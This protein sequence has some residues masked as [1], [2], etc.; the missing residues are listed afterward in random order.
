MIR[1]RSLATSAGLAAAEDPDGVAVVDGAETWS[2]RTLDERVGSMAAHLDAA[3]VA[4]GSRVAVLAGPSAGAVAALHAIARIGA[5]AVPFPTS[6][7][8]R[9]LREAIDLTQPALVVVGRGSADAVRR[10]GRPTLALEAAA[11][12]IARTELASAEDRDA[13]AVIVLT[14]GTTGRP[15]AAVLSTRALL[16]SAEAW[17]EALPPASGWLLAV[18]LA[19]VA[20]LGVIWR[21]ALSGVPLVLLER[22]D[23]QGIVS[24]LRSKPRPSHASL[25]PTTL[26]R[27]LDATGDAPPP[28]TL[29][30]VPLGGGWIDPVLV[31]RSLAAGWPVVPTYGLTEAGSGVTALPTSEAAAHAETAG[32]PL[33][34]VSIRIDEPDADGIGEI[35]VDSPGRFSGYLDDR[36]ATATSLTP[37]GWLRTGDVGRLD[38]DGRLIVVDRRTD[39]IV[40]GGEN[41]SPAEVEAVLLTHPA[42]ADAAVVAR[43]DSTFGHVPVAAIVVRADRPTPTTADLEAYCREHLARYKVPVAFDQRAALPRTA[44]GKLRRAELRAELGTPSATAPTTEELPA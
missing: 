3:G 22:P 10:L 15:K 12:T 2:W 34:G 28:D 44:S 9:E 41:V 38:G 17:L 7:T 19:H 32:R 24:A 36:A 31:R 20:G 6:L 1:Y 8:D 13:P 42:I 40:R 27:I 25:V 11:A 23:P 16:A 39:R 18:G 4:L 26:A 21:A 5:V 43:P 30:A 37:D 14:S 29:R 35:L 33:P